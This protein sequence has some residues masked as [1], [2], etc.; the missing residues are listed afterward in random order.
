MSA[1]P[2]PGVLVVD[3]DP[4]IRHL[5]GLALPQF[6][7][8]VWLA[9]GGEEAIALFQQHRHD[10]SLALLDVLM[11]GLDVPATL[12]ALRELEPSLRCCFM[13]GEPGGHSPGELLALGAE[14]VFL[15]PFALAELAGSLW[16]LLGS[17]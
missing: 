16:G 1:S 15:K 14:R 10:I 13:T 17:A 2:P 9:S 3:D 12:L 7:F 4:H 6:G 11:P 5:L 8:A